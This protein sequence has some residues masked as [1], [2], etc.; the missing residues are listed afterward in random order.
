VARHVAV[1]LKSFIKH[2]LRDPNLFKTPRVEY[3]LTAEP[4]TLE[5]V[6]TVARA[7]E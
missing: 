4:L 5:E 7:I 3:G 6:R 2:M 1:T